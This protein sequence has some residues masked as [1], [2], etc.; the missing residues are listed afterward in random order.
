MLDRRTYRVPKD[1][2]VVAEKAILAHKHVV[3]MTFSRTARS[4]FRLAEMACQ[5]GVV[6][7]L[8]RR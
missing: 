3:N 1:G 7:M 8:D 5:A 6:C 4:G 2:A